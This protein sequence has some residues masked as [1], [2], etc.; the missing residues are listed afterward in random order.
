MNA[1]EKWDRDFETRKPTNDADRAVLAGDLKAEDERR[2]VWN[3]EHR[4]KGNDE[5][6]SS[7]DLSMTAS[8]SAQEGSAEI[9]SVSPSPTSEA[10]GKM[11]KEAGGGGLVRKL[12]RLRVRRTKVGAQATQVASDVC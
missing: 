2:K 6:E 1:R 10:D 4:K 9:Q 5:K 12:R 11:E 7:S 3:E 8:V